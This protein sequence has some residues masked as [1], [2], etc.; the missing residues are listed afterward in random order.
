MKELRVYQQDAV[1]AAI[2]SSGECTI[3]MATGLG[4]TVTAVNLSTHYKSTIFTVDSEELVSQARDA[5]RDVYPEVGLIKAEIFDLKPITVASIQTLHRRLHLIPPN[6]FELQVVDEAHLYMAKTF[7]K[8]VEHFNPKLRCAITATPTRMDN[9]P[10][11]DIFGEIV[12]EYG[13]KQGIEDGY[14]V[15]LDAIRIRTNTSLDKVSTLAGEFNQGQLSNE[16]NT[17]QRNNQIADAYLKYAEGRRTIA[18]C[19][20][21]QHAMDLCDAFITKGIKATAISADDSLTGDRTQKVKDFKAG[22]YDVIM[23]CSILGKGF[24]LPIVSCIINASPTKSLTRFMQGIGRGTRPLT[25][26]IDGLNTAQ[27]RWSAIKKSDKK[28]CLIIDITDNTTRHNIVNCWNL[29]KELHPSDRVFI[30]EEKRQLLLE[31]RMNK[32]V[33]LEHQQLV[34]ER[35]SL[36][37]IPRIKIN[38]DSDGMKKPATEAQLKWL[39]NLGYEVNENIYTMAM[40]QAIVGE[41]PA[42]RAKI[43]DAKKLGYDVDGKMITNNEI[44]AI[45]RE[46]WIKL[47]KKKR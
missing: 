4:K 34:D 40:V 17:P 2:N 28:D 10:L 1:K 39:E 47:N 3:T 25:G 41:L 30:T 26:V 18:F 44:N 15:E 7:R 32:K 46:V 13:I 19:C 36:L 38:Y 23:N 21:I 31:T 22:K 33:I 37:K 11:S 8:G 20:S 43:E 35:V 24:D 14:L 42:S 16:I 5:F 27:E 6:Y 45:Q 9:L 12:Y 29:D